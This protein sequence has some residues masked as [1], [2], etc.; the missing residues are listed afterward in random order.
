[1]RL[2]KF[3]A[4]FWKDAYELLQV[5]YAVK[6]SCQQARRIYTEGVESTG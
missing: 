1:V 3:L 2:S 4:K 6:A 5:I